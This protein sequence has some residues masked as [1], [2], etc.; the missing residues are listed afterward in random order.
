[1]QT[2]VST[3][4]ARWSQRAII[5]ACVQSTKTMPRWRRSLHLSG[6]PVYYNAATDK[7]LFQPDGVQYWTV[8]TTSVGCPTAAVGDA[9]IKSLQGSCAERPDACT[10]LWMEKTATADDTDPKQQWQRDASIRV[11]DPQH[12]LACST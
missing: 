6:K 8:A 12:V 11:Y 3:T 5:R 2:L 10:G 7:V 4:L 1:M 9:R